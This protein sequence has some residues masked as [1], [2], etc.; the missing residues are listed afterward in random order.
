[1][2]LLPSTVYHSFIHRLS[3]S[4]SILC[5]VCFSP[6]MVEALMMTYFT[7]LSFSRFELFS[8]SP[9]RTSWILRL[10]LI[11]NVYII[12]FFHSS[13]IVSFT[14]LYM[15]RYTLTRTGGMYNVNIQ[16]LLQGTSTMYGCCLSFCFVLCTIMVA[17]WCLLDVDA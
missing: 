16:L 10:Y 17:S 2:G 4:S 13:P 9:K 7:T 1:M 6:S 8:Y 12:F 5:P 11:T 15:Y 14:S 3:F